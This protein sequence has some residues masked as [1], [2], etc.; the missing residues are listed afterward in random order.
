VGQQVLSKGMKLG[1]TE[2]G[3]LAAVGVDKFLVYR[4]LFICMH[5]HILCV[6]SCIKVN[7]LLVYYLCCFS[8]PVIALLSTGNELQNPNE[9]LKPGKIRDSNKTTLKALF[10]KE[11]YQVIDC[12]IAEDE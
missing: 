3:T 11:G 12:G 1:P 6:F 2:L 7:K 8:K 10:V 4:Y 9:V 5:V